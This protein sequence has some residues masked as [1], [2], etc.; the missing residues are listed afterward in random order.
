MILGVVH[1][2]ICIEGQSGFQTN[3]FHHSSLVFLFLFTVFF[4]YLL[5]CFIIFCFFFHMS[6]CFVLC[7]SFFC[8]SGLLFFL[9]IF[10]S[11]ILGRCKFSFSQVIVLMSFY[12]VH[13]THLKA[14][15]QQPYSRY[16]TPIGIISEYNRKLAV[17]FEISMLLS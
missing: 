1:E 2:N 4:W 3:N 8:P 12:I 11:W 13:F 9:F 5:I 6:Y 15:K 10:F 17:E 7:F 16:E 14:D